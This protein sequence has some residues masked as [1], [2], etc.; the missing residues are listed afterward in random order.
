MTSYDWSRGFSSCYHLKMGKHRAKS[1]SLTKVGAVIVACLMCVG[2][3]CSILAN[4]SILALLLFLNDVGPQM[5]CGTAQ[6]KVMK[7]KVMREPPCGCFVAL[8]CIYPLLAVIVG[9]EKCV[10]QGRRAYRKEEKGS[11]GLMKIF[12]VGQ[13][14]TT[15]FQEPSFH[16]NYLY[17]KN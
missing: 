3:G 11:H 5:P 1:S 15:C 14:M 8:R 10:T 7:S 4:C 6:Q 13:D 9:R 16:V 12:I 17:T 2:S